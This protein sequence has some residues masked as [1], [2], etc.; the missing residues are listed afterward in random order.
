MVQVLM[1]VVC[2]G[3]VV[4]EVI[5]TGVLCTITGGVSNGMDITTGARSCDGTRVGGG[6]DGGNVVAEVV[7]TGVL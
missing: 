2:E 6:G 5:S 4:A 1:V 7:S 3:S